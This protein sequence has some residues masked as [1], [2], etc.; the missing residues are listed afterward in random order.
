MFRNESINVTVVCPICCADKLEHR[1]SEASIKLIVV[2]IL[3]SS[4][5]RVMTPYFFILV[6]KLILFCGLLALGITFWA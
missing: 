4:V 2:F 3:L 1:I 5:F 6:T